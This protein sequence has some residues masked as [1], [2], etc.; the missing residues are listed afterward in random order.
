M[1]TVLKPS[2]VIAGTTH[3]LP[4][5][6]A[7]TNPLPSLEPENCD[8]KQPLP[9]VSSVGTGG[10]LTDMETTGETRAHNT[11]NYMSSDLLKVRMYICTCGCSSHIHDSISIAT[12]DYV[13]VHILY[14]QGFKKLGGM[15]SL[16][17]C[18][19]H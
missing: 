16:D 18:K 4:L 12:V 3:A 9:P 11:D 2:V 6:H 17:D 8:E 13:I 5:P 19:C 10:S 7:T 14:H 1:S 15:S